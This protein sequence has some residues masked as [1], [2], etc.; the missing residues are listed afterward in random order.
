MKK[1]RSGPGFVLTEVRGRAPPRAIP[2]P[3]QWP[4]ETFSPA[5]S[6]YTV[7]Q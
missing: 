1:A 3:Y 5:F 7:P 2:W 6:L 4:C